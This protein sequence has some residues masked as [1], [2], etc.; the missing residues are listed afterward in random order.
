MSHELTDGPISKANCNI[1]LHVL[2][3]EGVSGTRSPDPA[4]VGV[5]NR[6]TVSSNSTA[7]SC[8]G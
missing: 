6:S 7:I 4:L 8:R 3:C 1:A 2:L 5:A